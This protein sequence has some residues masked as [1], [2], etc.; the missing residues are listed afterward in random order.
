MGGAAVS[1]SEKRFFFEINM[2]FLYVLRKIVVPLHR[3]SKTVVCC[4]VM[5]EIFLSAQG[6]FPQAVAKKTKAA[7]KTKQTSQK[8]THRKIATKL[9]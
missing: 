3:C 8:T 4:S 2:C 6:I 1:A 5:Q 7:A 9:N